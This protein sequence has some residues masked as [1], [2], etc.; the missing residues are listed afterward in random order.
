M[1]GNAGRAA[2]LVSAAARE[3]ARVAVLPEL[4]LP[5]YDLTALAQDTRSEIMCDEAGRVWD[6]RLEPLTGAAVQ[7]AVAVLAGAAVR[8]PD[9]ALANSTLLVTPEGIVSVLYDKENLW[10]ADEAA[11]FRPGRAGGCLEVDGWRLGIAICYDMS[12]PEHARSATAAGAHAYLCSSAFAAGNE[13]RAAVY[14]AARALENTVYSVF[15]NPV[16]GPLGRP[17]AGGS[18]VHGPDGAIVTQAHGVREQTLLT[19]LD[20]AA[21]AN[22][23]QFLHMLA[24]FRARQPV[25]EEGKSHPTLRRVG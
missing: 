23:R 6:A 16:G 19:D 8:S 18:A 14:M 21:I 5:G 10:H 7:G 24:E 20:P 4:H 2:G 17:A 15:V 11:L 1:A 12:F 3:G 9:G 25:H 13:P 22:V